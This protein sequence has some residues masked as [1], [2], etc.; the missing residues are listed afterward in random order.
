MKNKF[1]KPVP[2]AYIESLDEDG[3]PVDLISLIPTKVIVNGDV[4]VCLWEDGTKTRATCGENDEFDI[5]VGISVCL[6]KR[7]FGKKILEKMANNAQVQYPKT[8]MT[9]ED[10]FRRA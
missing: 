4:V 7:I 8:P 5:Q 2:Q 1:R 9:L 6:G 3:Q 10:F